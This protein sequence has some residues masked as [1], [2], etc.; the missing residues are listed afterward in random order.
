VGT[1]PSSWSRLSLLSQLNL[2]SNA[3][4]GSIP[5]AWAQSGGMTSLLHLF[6][7]SNKAMCGPLPGTWTTSKVTTTDTLLGS[8][9]AQTSGLLS[10]VTSV[11]PDAWP[12]YMVGWTNAT[13]PCSS[14]FWTG[15]ACTGPVVTRLNLPY[16]T[17]AGSLPSNLSLV[18]GLKSLSLASNR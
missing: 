6:A 12:S 8:L 4:T 11:T 17:L 5:T 15:V 3:L 10:L 16:F 14:P 1:L 13:D 7:Q 9:C 2:A 18:S